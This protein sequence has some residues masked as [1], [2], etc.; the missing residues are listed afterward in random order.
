MV[1]RPK[2][3]DISLKSEENNIKP[4]ENVYKLE[5]KIL[6]QFYHYSYQRNVTNNLKPLSLT[7][8]F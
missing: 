5:A 8:K 6:N 2:L 3:Y 4:C 1:Q 7:F